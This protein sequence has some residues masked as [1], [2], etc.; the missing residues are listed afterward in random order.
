MGELTLPDIYDN[1]S[2]RFS[3]DSAGNLRILATRDHEHMRFVISQEGATRLR[4]LLDAMPVG[5]S[6][7][8]PPTQR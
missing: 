7:Q 8:A 5:S 3:I 6:P 4:G 1:S 2:V